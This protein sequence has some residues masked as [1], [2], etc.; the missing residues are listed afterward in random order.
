M[1]PILVKGEDVRSG[2]KAN[3]HHRGVVSSMGV[4]ELKSFK[5]CSFK[6]LESNS[7]NT[8]PCLYFPS[9]HLLLFSLTSFFFFCSIIF[10]GCSSTFNDVRLPGICPAELRHERILCHVP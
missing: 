7:T 6:L 9:Y 5:S 4:H 8:V 1:M 3:A 10:K 2:Q